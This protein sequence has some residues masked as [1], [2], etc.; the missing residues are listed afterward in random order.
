[1]VLGGMLTS[2]EVGFLLL[3]QFV[4][5]AFMPSACGM[6]RWR[7]FTSIVAKRE[8]D[9]IVIFSNSRIRSPLSLMWYLIFG[10]CGC[11]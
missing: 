2:S 7:A 3:V 9:G 6:F 5:I 1:M 10:T 8:L 11:R 4:Y